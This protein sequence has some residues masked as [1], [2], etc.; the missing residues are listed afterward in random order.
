MT[1]VRRGAPARLSYKRSNRLRVLAPQEE[2]NKRWTVN[3]RGEHRLPIRI[4]LKIKSL[5]IE[6]S[7]EYTLVS[8]CAIKFGALK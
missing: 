3:T 4:R 6:Q 1:R 7:F 8:I 2:E 5:S